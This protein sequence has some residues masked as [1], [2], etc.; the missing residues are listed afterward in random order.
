[1]NEWTEVDR[2]RIALFK[3]GWSSQLIADYRKEPL[4]DVIQSV[5]LLLDVLG[6]KLIEVE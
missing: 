6:E 2:E 1:M 4:L 5:N 3:A